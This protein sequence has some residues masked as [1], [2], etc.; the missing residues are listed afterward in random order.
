MHT[1]THTHSH[2]YSAGFLSWLLRGLA[3]R[4]V[5]GWE[6]VD[7][8]SSYLQPSWNLYLHE[9]LSAF[10]ITSYVASLEMSK[11]NK[12]CFIKVREILFRHSWVVEGTSQKDRGRIY[13]CMLSQVNALRKR[14]LVRFWLKQRVNFFWRCWAFSDRH[15]KG[16]G[17]FILETRSWAD[18]AVLKFGQVSSS[19]WEGSGH[20]GLCRSPLCWESAVFRR[21]T[22]KLPIIFFQK[23]P[24]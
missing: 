6:Q 3:A 17:V 14:R 8:A 20:S 12:L 11:G 19:L 7:G 15:F 5:W 13:N 23:L 18:R 4:K 10:W 22:L 1:L 9:F 24:H 2:S 16:A 21:Q